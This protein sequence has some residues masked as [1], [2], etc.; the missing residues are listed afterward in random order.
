MILLGAI[1][2]QRVLLT[3]SK[4]QD[5]RL[6]EVAQS[7]VDA[8]RVAVGPFVLHR[9][10][11]EVYDALDR[12]RSES[13]GARI[14]FT[15]V[16]DDAGLV[17]ASTDPQRA[18]IDLQLDVISEFALPVAEV[19]TDDGNDVVRIVEPLFVQG[20]EVGTVLTELDVSDLL[21]QRSAT[22][23]ALLAANTI[24]TLLLALA[25]YWLVA[26]LLR[27]VEL[28]TSH[29]GAAGFAPQPIPKRDIA[30]TDSA[31]APLL[32]NFNGMIDAIEAR[33]VAER[34]LA[35]RERFV[36]LGR[37]AS[38]LAHEINNP[39]GGL[40]NATDTLKSYADRPDVVQSSVEIL[41]R[42]LK[43]MR[44]VSQAILHENRRDPFGDPLKIED[45]EDLKLLIEPELRRQ[46][47][48]LDWDIQI[49]GATFT[50]VSSGPIRQIAL[51]LLLNATAAAGRDGQVGFAVTHQ[52]KCLELTVTD[53]GPGLSRHA[54][55]RLLSIQSLEPGGGVG[56]R[57]VG[58]L[59]RELKGEVLHARQN[60]ETRIS[61]RVPEDRE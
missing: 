56:L 42:G 58:D 35:E 14:L 29:M 51:N 39:L 24:A 5:E 46:D 25:G 59:V 41:D 10:V 44:D 37:L 16:A 18:P 6:R 47:Q 48:G 13:A 8:L 3:L 7:H 40:L 27:P 34:R 43:H 2:S 61:V 45:F 15:A 52:D 9:D 1:A 60:G 23:L 17:L 21:A 11:W 54:R 26:R 55:E 53:N 12:A 32:K 22:S 28:L 38:T 33:G 30:G 36:S 50:G 20:R 4:L 57:L 31:F 49:D 19:S